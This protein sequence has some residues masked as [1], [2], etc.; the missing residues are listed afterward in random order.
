MPGLNSRARLQ[1]QVGSMSLPVL[2]FEGVEGL[3]GPFNFQFEVL[4]DQTLSVPGSIGQQ[5]LATVA[6]R[7]GRSRHIAGVVTEAGEQGLHHDGRRRLRVRLES[8]LALLRHQHDQRMILNQSVVDLSRELLLHHGF[9]LP[10]LRF[11]LTR[12]YPVRPTTLQAG[13][14]DLVFLQRL[15][16]G[17]GIFFWSDV[18]EETEVV[19]FSDHNSHCPVLDLPPV[20]YTPRA[21]M[22][23]SLGSFGAQSG[24]QRLEVRQRM[25]ASEFQVCDR[26]EQQP[27]LAIAG[28]ACAN[29]PSGAARSAQVHFGIGAIDPDQ[30]R[31]QAQLLAERAAVESF[32]LTASGDITAFAPSRVFSLD[33]SLLCATLSGDYLI[34]RLYHRGSQKAGEGGAGEDLTYSNEATLIRRETPFRP[35]QPPRPQLPVT[36]TAR[37][38][39]SGPYAQLDEQGRYRL[40]PHFDRDEKSHGEASIPIR[41]LSPFGGPPGEQPTGMHLPL[42]DGAEVLL[43]CLNGDPDRPMIVGTLPNPYKASPVTSENAH[44]NRLRTAGDNE[45]CLDDKI[46]LEAIT[47]RTFVGHNILQL[48]AAALGHQIRLVSSQG[49]MQ[50]QAKKTIKVQSGDTLTERSG[51]D[52]V[53]TVENRHQTTTNSGEI[54]YQA[55]SDI[56]QSAAK[57]IRMEAGQNIEGSAGKHLRIDVEQGKQAT[58]HGSQASFTVQDGN[59]TIQAAQD[60]QIRGDGGGDICIGQNGGGLVIKADGTVQL[61][62]NQINLKGDGVS[63]NGVVN[64][65]VGG[66]AVMPQLQAAAPLVP[67]GILPLKAQGEPVVI[68]PAWSRA[69]VPVAE[70]VN[71]CFNVKNF[72]GGETATITVSEVKADGSQRQVAQLNAT[73]DDGMGHYEIPWQPVTEALQKD[74]E[75]KGEVQGQPLEYRFEVAVGSIRTTS[76]SGPLWLTRP[77][78]IDLRSEDDPVPDGTVVQLVMADGTEHFARTE[79]QQAYFEEVLVGPIL[80]LQIIDYLH[81][82]RE[83]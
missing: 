71:M 47:L 80:Q 40:R 41:R 29:A 27:G 18:E 68:N 52:L 69:R 74:F 7:D 19:R 15:L 76:P 10:Q 14:S 55:A 64:Y 79:K 60:I 46:D 48:N 30:V 13:E 83:P 38:E 17:A 36:M 34:T 45:L 42:L 21:G 26:S 66:G 5:G 4:A 28:A 12:S 9:T 1:L 32:H 25:V 51:N 33:A 37:V 81:T 62:G 8:R 72:K 73:L 49:A 56:R 43:S 20:R 23:P 54:H 35:A 16:A 50:W 53:Q 6:G 44:Q 61:Y 65:Q 57:N 77:L 82:D 58:V 24:I 11:L 67:Q 22:D 70:T 59:L 39:S 31:S 63:F 75:R 78:R 2:S 3:S